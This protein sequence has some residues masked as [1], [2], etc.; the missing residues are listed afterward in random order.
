MHL[1][2]GAEED[3]F[4]S[5]L[6]E[7]LETN[8]PPEARESRDFT[9]GQLTSRGIPEWAREWQATLFDNGWMVPGYPPELG[10][11][12]ATPLQTLI[13]MEEMAERRI[14][15]SVH[16]PGYA[17]V[18]PSLLEFGDESQR[19]IAPAAIRGDTVWCVGMSEPNAGS[20]LASLSTRAMLDGDNFIVNGQKVW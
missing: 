3:A 12:D 13:Y 8:V 16:F 2:W 6:V 7:F 18:G 20:D 4:R 15:R 5:E 11:R 14:T 1:R 10:G 17:I 9:E 19:A